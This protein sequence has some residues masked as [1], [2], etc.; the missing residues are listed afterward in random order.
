MLDREEKNGKL[1]RYATPLLLVLVDIT[2]LIFAVTSVE[3]FIAMIVLR[4]MHFTAR[5]VA[6]RF[7]CLLRCV[8]PMFIGMK[9]LLI[10]INRSW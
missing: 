2:K 10:D 8:V 4:A 5:R 3:S 7:T 9:I 6:R 1:I